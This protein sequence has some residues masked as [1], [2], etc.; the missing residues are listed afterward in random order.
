MLELGDHL[1]ELPFNGGAA[2]VQIGHDLVHVEFEG[3]G[4][5]LFDEAREC[6]PHFAGGAVERCDDRDP[7]GV[8][9]ARDM[10]GILFEQNP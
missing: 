9:R 8:S 3:A 7:D 2:D 4:A 5:G 10:L 1:D 6:Q